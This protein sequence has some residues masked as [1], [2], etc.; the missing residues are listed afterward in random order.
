VLLLEPCDFSLVVEDRHSELVFVILN[1]ERHYL[2]QLL[3]LWSKAKELECLLLLGELPLLLLSLLLFNLECEF[4]RL[5][6]VARDVADDLHFLHIGQ[7]FH[8]H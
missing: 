6:L 2:D 4:E 7:A 8:Q 5:N 1:L 3:E